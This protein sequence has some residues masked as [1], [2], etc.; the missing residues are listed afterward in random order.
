MKSIS[1][2]TKR[3]TVPRTL[4]WSRLLETNT[5]YTRSSQT[6]SHPWHTGK[7]MACNPIS[8]K[9]MLRRTPE[10]PRKIVTIWQEKL[11][12]IKSKVSGPK[13]GQVQ[14]RK[15]HLSKTSHSNIKKLRPQCSFM[16]QMIYK[17]QTEKGGH[18][19]HTTTIPPNHVP[20]V[21]DVTSILEL[22]GCTSCRGDCIH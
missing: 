7:A 21:S 18:T 4:T 15:F 2:L 9:G 14:L 17:N 20:L 11:K 19:H 3:N 5:C 8:V 13:P 12:T 22:T 10:R 6:P 1:H 16:G